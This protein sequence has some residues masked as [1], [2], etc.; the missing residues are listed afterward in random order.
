MRRFQN[1]IKD[2]SKIE[3]ILDEAMVCR[4][5]FCDGDIPYVIPMNFAYKDN[6]VYL[7]SA[8]EGRKLELLKKN[9]N[10]CLEAEADVKL[11][12]EKDPCNWSASYRCA[13][14]T[15]VASIISSSEE[16]RMAIDLIVKKYTGDLNPSYSQQSYD[17]II[18]IKIELKSLT[19][20]TNPASA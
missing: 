12:R 16:K 6:C 14:G 9:P 8:K 18:A 2:R 1:E 7:H 19:G 13:I 5:A 17:R 10:I 3:A 20:K 4:V 11:I 15:G